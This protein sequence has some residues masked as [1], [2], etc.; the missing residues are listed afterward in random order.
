MKRLILI[1]LLIVPAL[2]MADSINFGVYTRHIKAN[3]FYNNDNNLIALHIDRYYVA[4][5]TNSF[6]FQTYFGGL[7]K[8]LNDNVSF[9]Y[10][11]SYGYS[12]HCFL[13]FGG[14]NNACATHKH[15]PDIVPL[16][17]V[18]L[19]QEVGPLVFSTMLADYINL[20]VGI[21]F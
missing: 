21:N 16:A 4:S 18:R 12:R 11:L 13:I 6:G 9:V 1:L 20:S 19:Y 15:E 8:K 10:G 14:S 2:S 3:D 17:T 7:E 5:F